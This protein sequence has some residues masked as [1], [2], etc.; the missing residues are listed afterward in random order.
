MQ[1]QSKINNYHKDLSNNSYRLQQSKLYETPSSVS[2]VKSSK[3]DFED[4]RTNLTSSPYTQPYS[5]HAQQPYPVQNTPPKTLNPSNTQRSLS[6]LGNSAS[7]R[8][9]FAQTQK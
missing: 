7:C 1:T 8:N 5:S 4:D 2:Y 3:R 6:P 9:F